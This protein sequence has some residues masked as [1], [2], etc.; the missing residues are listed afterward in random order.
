MEPQVTSG[1]SKRIIWSQMEQ[2]GP[3]RGRKARASTGTNSR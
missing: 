1:P 3:R 2:T